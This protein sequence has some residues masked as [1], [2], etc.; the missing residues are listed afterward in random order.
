[1]E[2]IAY[3]GK[4]ETKDFYVARMEQH[5]AADEIAHGFYWEN[6]RGC[7]VGC[8]IHGQEHAKYE[9]ELGVP[10]IL[11][12]ALVAVPLVALAYLVLTFTGT[13]TVAESVTTTSPLTWAASAYP[14]GTDV[15]SITLHNNSP[16]PVDVTLIATVLPAGQGVT[17]VLSTA[18]LTIPSTGPANA[19]FTVTTT[20]SSGAVPGAYTITVTASR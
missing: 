5:K 8:T 12:I 16:A 7:A 17:A 6:G 14:G 9:T 13:V 20:V 18:L 4:Q 11:A 1:M 15:H 10:I 2:L 3:H 19:T